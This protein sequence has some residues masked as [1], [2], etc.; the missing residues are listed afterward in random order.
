MNKKAYLSG[1]YRPG[2]TRHRMGVRRYGPLPAPAP[3]VAAPK[4]PVVEEKP[5]EKPKA[6]KKTVKKKTKE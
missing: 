6:V 4:P 3:V 2:S 5:E 1:A